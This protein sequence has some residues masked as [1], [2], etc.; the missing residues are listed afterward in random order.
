VRYIILLFT[1]VLLVAF[2]STPQTTLKRQDRSSDVPAC[3]F[4]PDKQAFIRTLYE[5]IAQDEVMPLSGKLALANLHIGTPTFAFRPNDGAVLKFNILN[6]PGPV[7]AHRATALLIGSGVSVA[8]EYRLCLT[9][10][11]VVFYQDKRRLWLVVTAVPPWG[12]DQISLV[13]LGRRGD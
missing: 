12:A 9:G 5:R 4:I 13:P 7:E 10:I 1:L 2:L 6:F 3:A 8:K 11:E